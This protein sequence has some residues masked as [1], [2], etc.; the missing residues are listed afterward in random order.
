MDL[1][2]R[3]SPRIR[4]PMGGMD[5]PVFRSSRFPTDSTGFLYYHVPPPPHPPIMGGV[6]F[7]VTGSADPSS[8]GSGSDLLDPETTM[9]W[10]IPL[11]MLTK[12]RKHLVLR[13]M[14]LAD[15]LVSGELI[16]HCDMLWRTYPW[17]RARPWK[18]ILYYLEQPFFLRFDSHS[19]NICVVLKD[20]F[21]VSFVR[22]GRGTFKWRPAELKGSAIVRF[23][24]SGQKSNCLA[25]RVLKIVE[26]IGQECARD[27][28]APICKVAE[29]ELVLRQT[30]GRL[31]PRILLIDTDRRERQGLKALLQAPT[32]Q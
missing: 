30:P 24:Q 6:R 15:D 29:G 11:L 19:L 1:S 26:H 23:E 16:E 22:V 18:I 21:D 2:N 4:T 27:P 28:G 13:E 9:P 7:R 10:H 32:V 5:H 20:R 25:I 8:F 31:H 17:P 12:N 3:T 14:L